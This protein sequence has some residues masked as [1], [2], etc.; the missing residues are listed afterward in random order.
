MGP[1]VPESVDYSEWRPTVSGENKRK[2]TEIS[3]TSNAAEHRIKRIKPDQD[4]IMKWDR[5]DPSLDTTAG[6]ISGVLA[7]KPTGLIW[8]R[9][10]W[11]C[12]YDATFTI[13]GNL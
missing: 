11:S 8:D 10:N 9:T 2:I 3:S 13:L 1:K 7:W 5:A 6:R 4:D 12:A